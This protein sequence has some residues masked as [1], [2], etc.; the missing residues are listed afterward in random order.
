MNKVCAIFGGSR[1]IGKA[2][3]QL[4]AQKGYHLAIIARNLDAAKATAS[5]LGAGHLALSCDVAKEQDVQDTFEEIE[6]NLGHVNC[7][8]NAAGINRD[9]LLLRTKTE[10]MI[11]QLNINL[12]GSMLTCK[13]GIKSMIQHQGGAIVNIGSIV[14]HKGNSGQS[15]YSA[16][17]EGLVGF[18]RSLAK[19]VGRKKIRINVIAPGFI[20]TDMTSGLKE[21]QLKTMIPL[22]RFGE[23]HEVAQAVLFLLESP[24]ITGHVLVLDGGVQLLI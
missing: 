15:V 9:G 23:P 21:D 4:L 22:G 3:A 19:E 11:S 1:G 20:R 16:S 7:L 8:V 17:K 5:Q 18:S 2:V 13:A 6:K 24:Y 14:G 12:L 10:D